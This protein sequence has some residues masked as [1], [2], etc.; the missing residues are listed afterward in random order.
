VITL[1]VPL[2]PSTNHLINQESLNKCKSNCIL[3]NTS[4]GALVD[5]KAVVKA[6]QER[7]IAG[8]VFWSVYLFLTN[9]SFEG[10]CADVHEKDE[11]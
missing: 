6:L 3:I 11:G 10:F 4:R 1:H 2:L 9:Q 8:C 5:T 7:K